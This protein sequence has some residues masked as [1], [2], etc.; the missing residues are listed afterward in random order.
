MAGKVPL[1][2]LSRIHAPLKNEIL[3]SLSSIID[4]SAFVLGPEVE[5][6]EKI[7]AA[8]IGTTY[9]VGVNS[10]LDALKLALQAVGVGPGDEVITAANSF[11]ATSFAITATGATP[12]FVD[13]EETS[14]NM[15]PT[16]LEKAITPRTKVILPVHLFGQSATMDPIIAIAQKHNLKIVEDVAQG[17]K[18]QYKGK[19]CGAMGLA[20]CFSFYPGKNL[21]SMGE[22]GAV[23]TSDKEV[24]EKLKIL[25]NVGQKERDKHVVIGHNARLHNMQAGILSI[26]ARH[27]HT[28]NQ[29]RIDLAK[30]L[31]EA[32]ADVK[33]LKLPIAVDDR[34][35]VYHLFV[36]VTK[37]FE[38]REAFK[39]YLSENGVDNKVHYPTPI[40]LQPCYA[41]LNKGPGS[42][43]VAERLANTMLS[44]PMF[45]GMTDEEF[46]TLVS[47]IKSFFKK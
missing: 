31:F 39:K 13:V 8:Q 19:N 27:L 15:D 29:A 1:M 22:G 11:I 30:R 6:F 46:K 12:V 47:V 45:A 40:H 33:E 7:W 17:H 25:R 18:A 36:V 3:Q 37:D 20:G 21:G 4:R 5:E 28:H 34:S 35:H 23:T 41:H 38:T 43:P 42:F 9:C 10:G 14:Y 24:F 44:L 32:F 26:K 2:D 16:Q